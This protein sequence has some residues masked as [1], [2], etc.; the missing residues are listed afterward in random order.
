MSHYIS[1]VN[2]FAFVRNKSQNA[3]ML[4]TRGPR[5]ATYD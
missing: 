5:C 1:F 4:R 2:E 3:I